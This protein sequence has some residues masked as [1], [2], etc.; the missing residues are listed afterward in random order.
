PGNVL[1]LE[2]ESEH[3]TEVFTGFGEIGV[4]AEAVAE[5]AVQ[6]ARR[7]LAADVPVGRHLADQLLIPLALAGGG[8]F[9]T[10]PLSRHTTTN[11]EV[12]REF[13]EV[14]I[15]VTPVSDGVVE[16]VVGGA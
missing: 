7:Y 10:M 4:R 5:G 9:R 15:A 1:L 12:I 11:I 6:E 2:V 14:E 3:V 8:A 16:I 13:L